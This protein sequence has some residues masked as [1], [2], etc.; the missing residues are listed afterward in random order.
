MDHFEVKLIL[1]ERLDPLAFTE[2]WVVEVLN[3]FWKDSLS[4]LFW[5]II[6]QPSRPPSS[7]QFYVNFWI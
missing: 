5:N 2:W 1:W 7:V 4:F 6:S 3:I